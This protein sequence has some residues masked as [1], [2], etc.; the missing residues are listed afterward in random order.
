MAWRPTSWVIDGELDNTVRGWTIGWIRL[1]GRDEPLKLK[2]AGNCHPSHRNGRVVIQSTRLSVERL[3]ERAFELTD[4]QWT[5][6]AEQ[7]HEE[8]AFFMHQIG[9]ALDRLTTQ[10]A[11]ESDS[12]GD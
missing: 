10:D 5:E 9:D 6:Q 1:E 7:N 3:G 12:E 4:E 11:D 8:M 2:L